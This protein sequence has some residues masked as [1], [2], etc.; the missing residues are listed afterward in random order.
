MADVR[1]FPSLK[2]ALL[3]IHRDLEKVVKNSNWWLSYHDLSDIE[4]LVLLLEDRRFFQHR[5]I[6]WRSILREVL[7]ALTFQRHGGASTIDMQFVRTTTGFKERTLKR[8]SYEMLLAYLLQFRMGKL[9]ILRSYLS[10]MYL[11]SGI[12]GIDQ[13]AL[14]VYRKR[15]WGLDLTQSAMIASMMVY[16]RPLAPT[17]YWKGK[18]T[19]R[20]Q[21]GLKLFGKYAERYKQRLE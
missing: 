4:V 12:K 3:N 18:V 16:P 1:Q 8:K 7:K 17:D 14:I 13:A 11:G 10:I 9:A 21:Y 15:L 20:A 19:A 6:D 5:G 2:R